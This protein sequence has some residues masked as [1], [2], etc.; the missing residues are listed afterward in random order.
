VRC[1]WSKRG[2]G[3]V[4]LQK[5]ENGVERVVAFGSRNCNQAESRY[6][7][8]EGELLAAV[9]FVRLWRQ[10]LWGER[11]V[12]ES[13]HQPL[14]WILTNRKLTGKLARWAL[15]LSEFDFEVVHRPRVDNEMDCL[16]RYPQE[17]KRDCSGVRQ[18]GDLDKNPPLV[19]T[20]AS[21]LAWQPAYR[22]EGAAGGKAP[23]EL[24][25]PSADVW[26]DVA[27]LALLME[28]GYPPGADRRERDRFQ[29]RARGYKWRDTHLVRQTGSGVRVVH[30]V[31][32]RGRLIR[33]VHERAGHV[34]VKKTHSLLRPHN[35][36]MGLLTDVARVVR[37]CEALRQGAGNV[38]RKAPCVASASHQGAL[39]PLG[40]G[41][42]WAASQVSGQPVRASDGGTLQQE[43]H[44]G[45][46]RR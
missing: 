23:G 45:A 43:C 46:H 40:A 18:E 9:Y 11:F 10:Y 36:W 5:D 44:S 35:W 32:A 29:H 14:K 33:D 17:G 1:D 7:S 26:T 34:G 30:R 2:V 28:K 20:A 31:E 3:G 37:S 19:C 24:I 38:Q 39:L 27:L 25:L 13:D 4:L 8:F 12:L 22:E 21:C 42:R 6:S 15:M 16:S 41:L